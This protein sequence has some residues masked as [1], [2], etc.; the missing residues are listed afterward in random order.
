MHDVGVFDYY[1][2]SEESYCGTF[3]D[4]F[5]EARDKL[6]DN[7]HSWGYQENKEDYYSVLRAADVVISTA[8]H[9]FF[10]VAM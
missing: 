2:F 1:Y 8:K 9:E 7:I 5:T 4:I 3:T 10:G 6:K